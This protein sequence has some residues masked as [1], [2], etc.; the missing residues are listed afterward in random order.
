MSEGFC[1]WP[2]FLSVT[3]Q[4]AERMWDICNFSDAQPL[5]GLAKNLETQFGKKVTALVNFRGCD[6]TM[7]LFQIRPASFPVTAQGTG[8]MWDICNFFKPPTFK[9]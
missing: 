2:V 6:K 5:N 7:S 8:R 3:A 1:F 4:R 9:L